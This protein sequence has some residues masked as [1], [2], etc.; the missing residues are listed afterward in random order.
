MYSMCSNLC[1]F[2]RKNTKSVIKVFFHLFFIYNLPGINVLV[3]SGMNV[4]AGKNVP[5]MKGKAGPS[6]A[7][8]HQAWPISAANQ[9]ARPSSAANQQ[10]DPSSAAKEQ[11]GLSHS[12]NQQGLALQCS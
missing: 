2:T 9:Q 7:A 6:S 5:V 10:P 11:S 1:L 12:A 3:R 8:N 4:P